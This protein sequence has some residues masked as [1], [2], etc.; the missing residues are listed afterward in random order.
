LKLPG[1][2]APSREFS[3]TISTISGKIVPQNLYKRCNISASDVRHAQRRYVTGKASEFDREG[4]YEKIRYGF[5]CSP[6]DIPK[7]QFNQKSIELLITSE[8]MQ[9]LSYE[10]E[11]LTCAARVGEP[12]PE[13]PP[14]E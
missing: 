10:L 3:S 6:V 7:L 1:L 12:Q 13:M 14:N 11:P 9:R 2:C 5:I 4:R 8:E